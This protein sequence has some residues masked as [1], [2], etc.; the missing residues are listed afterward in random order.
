MIRRDGFE[1]PQIV[2]VSEDAG[3][4]PLPSEGISSKIFRREN[5]IYKLNNRN[6][7]RRQ[8][9]DLIELQAMVQEHSEHIPATRIVQAMYKGERY[10]CVTQPFINGLEVKNTS[11]ED[12][13]AALQDPATENFGFVRGL[14]E[15]F[16]HRIK[17]R[18]LYPDIVGYPKDPDFFNSINLII[19]QE[20]KKIM[21]CDVGLSPHEDTLEAYGERFYK[22]ENV[23]TYLKK[24][25]EF[26]EFLD[27]TRPGA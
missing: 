9:D 20:T 16:L 26:R 5:F 13:L 25:T 23:T 24:M 22:S 1:T 6:S 21:L 2:H 18:E 27:Q 7:W 12:V 15:N 10:T 11:R 14:V 3:Y 4:V 19:E 8:K 17:Q